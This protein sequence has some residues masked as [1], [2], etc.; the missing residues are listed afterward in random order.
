MKL[1]LNGALTVGTMDGAN[2]EIREEVGDENIFIF[3]LSVDEVHDLKA[4][5]YIPSKY[6]ES[7]PLLKASIDLLYSDEFTPGE[8]GRLG[9]IADNL[10]HHDP[11]LVLADFEDYVRA[12]GE[13]DKA[14]S[15]KVGWARKAIIN[16]AS[17]G[18]FSSDR[19]IRD[20]VD[21]IWKLEK[22]S[23]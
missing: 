7:D 19:S 12:Q 16:T 2:V 11:F 20:Y 21:G 6:Y 23:V 22:V 13:I 8:P 1:A 3:G 18:K 4:S 17:M 15:D 5:H 9:S 14:Y 10:I